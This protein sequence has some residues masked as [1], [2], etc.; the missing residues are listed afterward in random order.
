M[1]NTP[2]VQ[3]NGSVFRQLA[4]AGTDPCNMVLLNP[5]QRMVNEIIALDKGMFGLT[6]QIGFSASH[7]HKSVH[8]SSRIA[9]LA[10]AEDGRPPQV[11]PQETFDQLNF[12][13]TYAFES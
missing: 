6:K 13:M 5:Q 9:S 8:T 2:G 4:L 11:L 12:N 10:S 3:I 7:H 1:I